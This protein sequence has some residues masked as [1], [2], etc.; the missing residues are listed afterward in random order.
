MLIDEFIDLSNQAKQIEELFDLY[1]LGMKQF[2]YDRL[3]FCLMNDHPTLRQEA[4][5]GFSVSYPDE[6]MRH[7]EE[8][9]YES[10]DPVRTS[11]FREEALFE[12]NRLRQTRPTVQQMKM[13]NEADD[14]GLRNG[15]GIPVRGAGGAL[16]GFG[17]AMSSPETVSRQD[18]DRA[19]LFANQFYT[20]FW[21]IMERQQQPLEDTL[22]DHEK[23]IL[24]WLAAGL[25]KNDVGDKLNISYHTVNY[26]VRN[27]LKKLE[28]PNVT[29]AACKA[30]NRQYITL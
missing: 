2:G 16:A 25:T 7:Y 3:L 17:A 24:R 4:K 6:W 14:V 8:S 26:H 28:S 15:I 10:I 23:D 27:I 29:A 22:S 5:H 9:R 13:F 11:M 20:C 21:R 1:C 30:L 12:W 18:Y 19:V